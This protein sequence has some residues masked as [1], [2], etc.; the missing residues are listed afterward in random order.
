M[1][2]RDA[3]IHDYLQPLDVMQFLSYSE[4]YAVIKYIA[5]N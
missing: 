1:M 2:V 5:D 4:G 3:T